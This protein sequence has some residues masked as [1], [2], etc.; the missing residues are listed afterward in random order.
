MV[1]NGPSLPAELRRYVTSLARMRAGTEITLLRA[2]FETYPAMLEAIAAAQ[3]HI[4]LETYILEDD[5]TGNRFA[6]ALR[7]RAKAGV[8]VRVL[9]DGVGGFGI[10][11]AWIAALERDGIRF[12]EYHPVAPWRAR[13]N[14]TRRDHRKIMV[15]DNE[16]AFTGGINI[17]DDYADVADGGR[18]WHDIHCRLRGAIV[19]DLARLFRRTWIKSGGDAFPPPARDD[20]TGRGGILARILET[21]PLRR[22]RVIRRA[23]L[24]AIAAARRDVLLENAYFLPDRP[25]RH[26]LTRAAGRGVDVRVIVPG[27]SDVKAIE[28]AGMYIYRYL[29]KRGVRI[30]RWRGPMMHAKTG[31]IDGVWATVGSYNL[32]ARSMFY[33]LEVIAEVIAPEFGAVMVDQFERDAADTLPFDEA[34]WLALPWWKKSLAWLAFQVRAWL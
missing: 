14:L 3:S 9:F 17:S 8:E 34:T 10:D 19:L 5:R 20:S 4:H 32:D 1:V 16:V 29:A 24:H 27:S 2:G 26:A 23:Y 33:N 18:G 30:L 31:V 21:G 25:L 6:A 22:K 28:Y 7:E 13:W 11:R 12:V 15:V